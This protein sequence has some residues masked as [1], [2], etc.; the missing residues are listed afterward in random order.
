MLLN[1]AKRQDYGF[2]HFGVIKGKPTWEVK[3]ALPP[4]NPLP[5]MG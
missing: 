3:I 1:A 4:T 2:Y 5:R